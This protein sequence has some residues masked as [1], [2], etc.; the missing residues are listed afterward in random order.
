[1]TTSKGAGAAI[2]GA[3]VRVTV[4]VKAYRLKLGLG[5]GLE[6]GLR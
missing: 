6:L 4:G 1:M 3:I 2:F 5:L